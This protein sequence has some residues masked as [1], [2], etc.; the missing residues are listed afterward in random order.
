[1]ASSSFVSGGVV[2]DVTTAG[3]E[4][5]ETSIKQG[6][7]VEQALKGV[8]KEYTRK[9]Q[10]LMVQNVSGTRVTYSGGNFVINRQTGKL[11]R[12]I[13]IF[14]LNPLAGS[15]KATAEYAG[16]V[17][18]GHGA[19]DLKQTMQGK[20]VPLPVDITSAKAMQ[21]MQAQ[22]AKGIAGVSASGL[23]VTKIT[24]STGRFMGSR[25]V[26]FRRVGKTGW[27]IPAQA[28]RPFGQAA[29]EAIE[30]PFADAVRKRMEEML[31]SAA[32][33]EMGSS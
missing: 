14:E 22:Q 15:V 31:Q 6:L 30:Q 23:K 33:D 20:I 28:P 9:T 29:A 18:G 21:R 4:S 32:Y 13:Q 12:S 25:A 11:A 2:I 26:V 7:D 8:V 24:A 17:E 1:M 16:F 27:I 3:L 10:A 5:L 19:I